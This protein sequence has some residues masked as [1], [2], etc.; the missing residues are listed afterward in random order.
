MSRARKYVVSGS[1]LPHAS[2]GL[3][4]QGGAELGHPT[5]DAGPG[6]TSAAAL[7]SFPAQQPG[8]LIRLLPLF[9]SLP[10]GSRNLP[11]SRTPGNEPRGGRASGCADE[12]NWE[13]CCCAEGAADGWGQGG[14]SPGGAVPAALDSA[15]QECAPQRCAALWDQ[16]AFRPAAAPQVWCPMT[17]LGLAS[18]SKVYDSSIQFAKIFVVDES[19]VLCLQQCGL[20]HYQPCTNTVL[21][22]ALP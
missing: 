8:S 4:L 11:R 21:Q 9:V 3:A 5:G 12:A 6:V 15:G 10:S 19:L 22:S 16:A 7:G 2:V 1:A 18:V 14:H 17:A 13:R 20:K